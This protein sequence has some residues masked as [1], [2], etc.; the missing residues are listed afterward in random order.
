MALGIGLG[1]E[2]EIFP[3][4]LAFTGESGLQVVLSGH[5]VLLLLL[6]CG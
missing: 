6:G 1:G 4:G 3:V 5:A 2:S